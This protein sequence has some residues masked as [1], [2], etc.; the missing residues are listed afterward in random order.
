MGLKMARCRQGIFYI[1]H[2]ARMRGT[3][4]EVQRLI[5]DMAAADGK[6]CHIELPQDPGQAGK[7]QADALTRALAGY[8]VRT[9]P[10]TGSKITRAQPAAVQ[11]Q[12]GNVKLVVAAWNIPFLDEL[13]RFPSGAH[14]DQVDT[15]ADALN[16]LAGEYRSNLANW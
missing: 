1:Q 5:L 9:T 16:A 4:M 6:A 12:A 2:V 13:S 11:A 3:P 7:A 8:R 10:V 14:D 15:F